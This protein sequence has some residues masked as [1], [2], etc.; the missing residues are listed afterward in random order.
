MQDLWQPHYEI[1]SKIFLK[2]FIEL[3]INLNK[4]IK[5]MKHVELNISTVFFDT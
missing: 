5:N 4:I 1:L 3:T 2:E